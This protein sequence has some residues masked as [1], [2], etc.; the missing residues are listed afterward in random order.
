MAKPGYYAVRRGRKTGV[1]NTWD[2]CEE[3]TKNYPGSSYKKFNTYAE[4][5]AFVQGQVAA[6]TSSNRVPAPA[7]NAIATTSVAPAAEASSSK[8]K[9]SDL[10]DRIVICTDGACPGNGKTGSVAGVG[11]WFGENDARNI[12]ERLPGAQTNNCAELTAILRALET[13]PFGKETIILTTD[14][15]YSIDCF[16]KY[17]P[18]WRKNRWIKADGQPVKNKELL[19]LISAHLD[20][21]K[22]RGQLVEFKHVR[23]HSGHVG[24][25]GADKL[26]VAGAY[27]P[28]V[29][30]RDWSKDKA[31][32][33]SLMAMAAEEE[34][35][36]AES[37]SKIRKKGKEREPFRPIPE[38]VQ[39]PSK[40]G[41]GLVGTA[42][43]NSQEL[44]DYAAGLVDDPAVDLSF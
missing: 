7:S 33:L 42:P 1:F 10:T 40:R 16:N 11:V 15:S 28:E 32:F 4:A 36:T 12:S 13:V 2:E 9:S 25:E 3:Y 27:M 44:A 31:A 34:T 22:R 21:R 23:G 20:E 26:A 8:R 17:I 14:S 38:S 29:D 30:E 19:Q 41:Q 24:N 6:S 18:G 39:S 43:Q 37:P 35:T 5:V